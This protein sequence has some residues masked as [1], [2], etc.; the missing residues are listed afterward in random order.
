MPCK[1]V[2]L[3]PQFWRIEQA[4]G[5][6]SCLDLAM[7]TSNRQ[8]TA[9][10]TNAIS[11]QRCPLSIMQANPSPPGNLLS[12][13]EYVPKLGSSRPPLL[14]SQ[15]LN[16]AVQATVHAGARAASAQPKPQG[17]ENGGPEDSAPAAPA[18][19]PKSGRQ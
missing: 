11:K 3:P 13:I 7:P 6:R 12:N 9:F 15:T 4:D 18:G 19:T 17:K 1:W 2:L 5:I 8:W 14:A 16:S 10:V